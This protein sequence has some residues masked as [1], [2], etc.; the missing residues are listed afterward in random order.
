VYQ[1]LMFFT[2]FVCSL[3]SVSGIGCATTGSTPDESSSSAQTFPQQ[4]AAG[5]ALYGQH[6]SECHGSAGQGDTAPRLVGLK[7]G[8]LPLE[9]PAERKVRKTQFVTVADVAGFVVQHMPPK[10]GGSLTA[11]EYWAILAFDLQANGINL[12]GKLTPELAGTLTIPR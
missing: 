9:P 4:V 10:K 12:D 5:Q 7:E 1:R 6:C 2:G 3:A 11:D 8:A